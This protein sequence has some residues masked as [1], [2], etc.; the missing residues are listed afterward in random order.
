M[1]IGF[2]V[3][4][5]LGIT[6]LEH[7]KGLFD[8][9]LVMTDKSSFEIIDFCEKNLIEIFVG[10]PRN[11]R[12]NEFIKDKE[13]D[14]IASVNYLFLIDKKIIDLGR[15]LCFNIHGSL[16]PKYR[17]RTPHV[18]A[19]INNEDYTGVTAH[20]IDENCDTGP[21]I[22]QV[23][24]PIEKTDTGAT[25]LNKYKNLYINMIE[26]ILDKFQNGSIESTVQD[27][28]KA[29][30]FGKRTPEDGLINWDW[31]VERIA[32]W[33]RAQANPYPGAFTYYK[34]KKIII[35]LVVKSDLGFDSGTPNGTILN[36]MPLIVKCSNSALEIRIIRNQ[37]LQ[38]K[39][40]D[41]FD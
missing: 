36:I 20:I 13:C 17:G 40:F 11:E 25:I 34:N 27:E 6:I 33:I 3:S 29:T 35:D 26:S 12:I 18:W 14:V 31:Q 7:F 22:E 41:K 39:K 2:L 8:V 16:L 32:N 23:A 19:I 21:I 37:D 10:N 5:G 15:G 38:I 4:G 1:K 24:I 30:Y 28:T 9:S